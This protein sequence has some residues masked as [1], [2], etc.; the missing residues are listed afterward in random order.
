MRKQSRFRRSRWLSIFFV[1]QIAWIKVYA[2][3]TA[4]LIG[5]P[6]DGALKIN[7]ERCHECHSVDGRPARR[8]R[9]TDP[10]YCGAGSLLS[11]GAIVE[12]AQLRMY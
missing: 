3:D 10:G 2:L 4:G 11:S 5:D 12:L 7:D 1:C 8:C 6:T 9:R